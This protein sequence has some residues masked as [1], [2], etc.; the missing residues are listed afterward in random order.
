MANP[1][2]IAIVGA[3]S[4]ALTCAASA[5]VPLKT[6]FTYSPNASV[7]TI[8]TGFQE[9][10]QDACRINPSEVRQLGARMRMEQVCTVRLLAKAV[11]ATRNQSLIAFHGEQIGDPATRRQLAALT[12]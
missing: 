6:E 7:E 4:V 10:A 3:A 11:E 12:R 8:Y 5:E 1:I 9:T 2:A